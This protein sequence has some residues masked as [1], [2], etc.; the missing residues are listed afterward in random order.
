MMG[1]RHS[2]PLDVCL[3]T[4]HSFPHIPT[5]SKQ[6]FCTPISDNFV[7][8]MTSYWVSKKKKAELVELCD[9]LGLECV[10]LTLKL[11]LLYASSIVVTNIVERQD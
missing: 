1:A 9:Q 10:F 5:K 4:P 7:Y 6:I 11:C 8:T 3:P 2:P